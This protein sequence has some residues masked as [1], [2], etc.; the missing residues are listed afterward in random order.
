MWAAEL[1][2]LHPCTILSDSF[3]NNNL[4]IFRRNLLS[5]MWNPC[6]PRF[7]LLSF[8]TIFFTLLLLSEM[9]T[10]RR[11]SMNKLQTSWWA[12]CVYACAT[13]RHDYHS[14]AAVYCSQAV[15]IPGIYSK[16]SI[17]Q[18]QQRHSPQ[19]MRMHDDGCD[20]SMNWYEVQ[21]QDEIRKE[22]WRRLPALPELRYQVCKAHFRGV[23]VNF[24]NQQDIVTRQPVLTSSAAWTT[25]K[26]TLSFVALLVP[27]VVHV[28]EQHMP[29]TTNTYI[30]EHHLQ[31]FY[32]TYI[33][34]LRIVFVQ[35]DWRTHGWSLE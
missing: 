23:F 3:W 2:E 10:G 4:E 17:A 15:A 33:W 34:F 19:Y 27:L 14:A 1:D 22:R 25:V 13:R 30:M 8:I 5:K 29:P 7:W 18:S 20:V 6:C 12:G 35:W 11:Y 32:S 26:E 9:P 24:T 28:L 16:Y 31:H 21:M